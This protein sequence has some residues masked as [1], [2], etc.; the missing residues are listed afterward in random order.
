MT[1]F[2]SPK[3]DSVLNA[4]MRASTPGLPSHNSYDELLD[5]IGRANG[6]PPDTYNAFTHPSPQTTQVKVLGRTGRQYNFRLAH[7]TTLLRDRSA[8]I[9]IVGRRRPKASTILTGYLPGVSLPSIHIEFGYIGE[10]EDFAMRH[11][12]HEHQEKFD[13]FRADVFLSIREGREFARKN[14]ERDLIE[15]YNPPINK[16]HKWHR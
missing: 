13:A 9:Y 14:I 1:N 8:G 16:Q 3:N 4:L 6:I 7:R 10:T 15:N 11:S 2:F 12:G 5:L